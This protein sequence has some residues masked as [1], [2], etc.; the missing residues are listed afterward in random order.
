MWSAN[1]RR[2][3][4]ETLGFIRLI[5]SVK[6]VCV[7]HTQ[8]IISIFS[9]LLASCTTLYARVANLFRSVSMVWLFCGCADKE[10]QIAFPAPH[11]K[12]NGGYVCQ[13]E[14]IDLLIVQSVIFMVIGA[15]SEYIRRRRW[16]RSSYGGAQEICGWIEWLIFRKIGANLKVFFFS[17]LLNVNYVSSETHTLFGILWQVLHVKLL[18]ILIDGLEPSSS[19]VC[20]DGKVALTGDV[21]ERMICGGGDVCGL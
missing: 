11:I 13:E 18:E 12:V 2:L 7:R 19:F 3:S 10:I 15:R 6:F 17:F 16:A 5:C 20:E 14:H 21:L 4:D 1:V 8:N 9:N